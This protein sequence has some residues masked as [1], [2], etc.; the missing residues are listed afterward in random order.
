MR[1]TKGSFIWAD[2]TIR[3]EIAR[4]PSSEGMFLEPVSIQK[5]LPWE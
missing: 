5:I 2:T 4:K 3:T 1:P